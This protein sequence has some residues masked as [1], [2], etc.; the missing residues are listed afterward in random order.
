MARACP[1]GSTMIPLRFDRSR[2]QR[3]LAEAAARLEGE[4]LL[5]DGAAAAAWFSDGRTTE[6]LDLIGLGGTQAER[7]ALMEFAVSLG[8]PVEAVNSAADFFVRKIAD[9]RQ[10]LEPLVSGRATIYRP[11]A[12]LFLLLKLERLTA[13]DLGDCLALIA[14][15]EHSD[16]RIDAVRI[17]ARL[18]ALA[19]T[20]D[21]ALG[22][23][24]SVLAAALAAQASR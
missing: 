6:D 17:L 12:T 8:L 15:C 4:W 18:G 20:E 5:I 2:I 11:T 9:W 24:R 10:Q 21:T 22:E 13:V 23:R 16:E 3:V 1:Y 19:V 7:L 14:H